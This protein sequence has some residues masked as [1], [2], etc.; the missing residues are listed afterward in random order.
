MAHYKMADKLAHRERLLGIPVIIISALIGT[1]VFASVAAQAISPLEKIAVGMF[2]LVATVLSALQTFFRYSERS[3]KHR[4]AG[5]RFASVRRKL[6]V[7][8][9]QQTETQERSYVSTLREELDRLAEQS[10]NVPVKVFEAIKN[11]IYY[12]VDLSKQVEKASD[13]S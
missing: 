6:E 7:I 4:S 8:Y 3:E 10:P 1:A 11:D 12:P 5:A 9:A 13:A 2:S